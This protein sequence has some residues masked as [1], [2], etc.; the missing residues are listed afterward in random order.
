[1]SKD[2]YEIEVKILEIDKKELERK[3]KEIGAKKLFSDRK[4]IQENYDNKE[5]KKKSAAIRVR[6]MGKDVFIT[7]KQFKEIRNNIKS[8]KEIEFE[9]SSDFKTV[10]NLF[11]VLGLK[12]YHRIE[13][14]RTTYVLGTTTFD[15]DTISKPFKIP[16]YYEIEV[17]DFKDVDKI[18]KLL[19][20]PK[21]KA[22]P[23]GTKKLLKYY[24][25]KKSKN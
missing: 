18:L 21:R 22:L 11:S 15:I 2:H 12:R 9:V 5:L 20:V 25:N 10:Q 19:K 8:C 6:Q 24:E 1:M 4:V 13:K 7:Y 17:K 14:T 23:W 16:T 3:L